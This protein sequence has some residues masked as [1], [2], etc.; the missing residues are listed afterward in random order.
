METD[1]YARQEIIPGWDQQKLK[2]AVIGVATE[3]ENMLLS[4]NVCLLAA[5]LGIGKVKIDYLDTR[6]DKKAYDFKLGEALGLSYE[7][8]KQREFSNVSLIIDTTNNDA[9]KEDMGRVCAKK[10]IPFISVSS[11]PT[12]LYYFAAHSTDYDLIADGLEV[13]LQQIENDFHGKKHGAFTSL[14]ASGIALDR[15]RRE[16]FS[17]QYEENAKTALRNRQGADS[18]ECIVYNLQSKTRF[19]N[20]NDVSLSDEKT[21]E[22]KHILLAGAGGVGVAVAKGLLDANVGT[23]TIVDG[24]YIKS[25]NLNR[26]FFYP[27]HVGKPKAKA[28]A[29]ELNEYSGKANFAKAVVGLIN[30]VFVP[31][32]K[33]DLIVSAVDHNY[34]RVLLNEIALKYNIPL[35]ETGTS[36]ASAGI[37]VFCPSKTYCLRHIPYLYADAVQAFETKKLEKAKK[38]LENLRQMNDRDEIISD[39]IIGACS[40]S[41]QQEQAAAG[42]VMPTTIAGACALA[43]GQVI[44]QNKNMA[45]PKLYYNANGTKLRFRVDDAITLGYCPCPNDDSSKQWPEIPWNTEWPEIE[46][47]SELVMLLKE[48]KKA[49]GQTR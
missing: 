11:T 8:D 39:L 1:V 33:P 25:H 24:D 49:Y 26:Q 45:I 22:G 17:T 47:N 2:T 7:P 10:K 13:H 41:S 30:H 35:I 42:V 36:A 38:S 9:S 19:D 20:F 27:K 31:E 44:L 14:M 12:K 18:L 15:A 21:Y 28:I 5:S 46:R 29:E 43:E 16:I 40:C 4:R 23:I 34:S 3:A 32:P 6:H 37:Q 48:R